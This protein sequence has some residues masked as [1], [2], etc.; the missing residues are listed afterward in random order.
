MTDINFDTVLIRSSSL[1]YLFTEPKSKA[2]KE[3]GNMSA[4]A[5]THLKQVYIR[6]KYGRAK[7]IQTRAMTKG[8]ECE[9]DSILMLSKFN[10]ELYEKNEE[11][12]SNQWIT[13]LPD[14]ITTDT[15]IDVKTC[16]DIWTF[17]DKV[18]ESIPDLYYAQIQAYLWLTNRTKGQISYCLTDAT[19]QMVAEEQLYAFRKGNYV[20]ELSPDFIQ[21][22]KEIEKAMTYQDIPLSEKIWTVNVELD[23]E[24]IEKIPQKVEKARQF[25]QEYDQILKNKS[26]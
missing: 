13:G 2:D 14:I 18:G 25:L 3:A 19:D 15:V 4:T 11:R 9:D 24:F 10:G 22:S 1:S 6:E 12:F 17:H 23:Q 16:Q 7:D 8:L 5:K 21:K 20:T 26:I